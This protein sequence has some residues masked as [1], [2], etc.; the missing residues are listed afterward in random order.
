MNEKDISKSKL[1]EMLG[2]S[3]QYVGRILNETANLTVDSIAK[4]ACVLNKSVQVRLYDHDEVLIAK[5]LDDYQMEGELNGTVSMAVKQDVSIIIKNPQRVTDM[6]MKSS[7]L[8]LNQ[9][10]IKKLNIY[11]AHGIN[12]DCD[13]EHID[14]TF[15]YNVGQRKDE[16]NQFRLLLI[17]KFSP[18]EG[19]SGILEKF[20]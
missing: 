6:E 12:P 15:N 9:F 4:I 18:G 11:W 2:K 17:V 14:M 19:K 5:S 3:R 7:S 8:L 10:F 13:V 16:Q 20:R 1:A